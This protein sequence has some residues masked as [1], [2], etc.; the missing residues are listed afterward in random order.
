MEFNRLASGELQ[1]LPA[2]HV[3]TGMGF[4]RLA[5][6]LQ[7]KSRIMIQMYSRLTR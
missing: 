1:K 3:D 7:V 5:M 2:R 6:V 4:E